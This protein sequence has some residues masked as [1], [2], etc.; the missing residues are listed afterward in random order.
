MRK[1]GKVPT[2]IEGHERMKGERVESQENVFG[3]DALDEILHNPD[4]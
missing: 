3:G 4:S 1:L 2:T